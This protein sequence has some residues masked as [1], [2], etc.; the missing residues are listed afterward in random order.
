MGKKSEAAVEL[1]LTGS[2]VPL[3]ICSTTLEMPSFFN[4]WWT[5]GLVAK[6]SIKASNFVVPTVTKHVDSFPSA[7][8]VRFCSADIAESLRRFI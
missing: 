5:R 3:P 1:A 8:V 4:A 6:A 7:V 2:T